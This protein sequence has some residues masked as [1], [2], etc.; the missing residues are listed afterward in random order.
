MFFTLQTRRLTWEGAR[1]YSPLAGDGP[2]F[3]LGAL[4]ASEQTAFLLSG[5]LKGPHFYA[6]DASH[7]AASPTA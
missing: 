6:L 3:V 5:S 7:P 4:A 2:G 1:T